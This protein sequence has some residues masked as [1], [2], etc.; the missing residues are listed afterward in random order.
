MSS[1]F[2]RSRNC[3]TDF[4]AS[5]FRTNMTFKTLISI[6]LIFD[7]ILF[8]SPEFNSMDELVKGNYFN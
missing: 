3:F 4:Y 2:D 7:I 1:S 6:F 8:L 5:F